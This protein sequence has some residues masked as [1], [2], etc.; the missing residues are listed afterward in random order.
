MTFVFRR[1]GI[2]R[3]GFLPESDSSRRQ[4]SSPAPNTVM[5]SLIMRPLLIA[6]VLQATSAFSADQFALVGSDGKLPSAFS[7]SIHVDGNGLECADCHVGVNTSMKGTDNLMPKWSACAD[8]H[9]LE[10]IANRGVALGEAMNG[11]VLKVIDDYLPKFHHQRHIDKAKVDCNAC[12]ANLDQPVAE[13]K[14]AHL[15]M[16]ADCIDCHTTRSVAME[17]NTC[18]LPGE[19]LVPENHNVMWMQRHGIESTLAES[20][21][22]MCHQ[23]GTKLDCQSCHQGDAVINPHPK[24][25]M[26]RHGQDAHLSDFRCGTCHEQRSFCIDCHRDMN[27]LPA[28]HFRAGFLTSSGG[29]HGESAQFDLESCMSCHDTPN[30]EPTCARCHAN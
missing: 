11:F 10:D 27:I 21:C 14:R 16:M 20:N 13:G 3:S 4:V 7:H 29:T 25:Y 8:C 1:A 15:P 9:S 24:N 19:N 6:L 12:H 5:L 22:T 2:K 18:H 23:S 17:C 26:S 28:D 30:A